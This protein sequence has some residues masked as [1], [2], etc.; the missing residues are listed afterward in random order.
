MSC[1][2]PTT[3][4]KLDVP[5]SML[6][7]HPAIRVVLVEVNQGGDLWADVF[8]GLPVK[9]RTTWSSEPKPV[10]AARLLEEYQTRTVTHADDWD[11]AATI[12]EL[13]A[14]PRAPHD[15]RVDAIGAGVCSVVVS[16]SARVRCCAGSASRSMKRDS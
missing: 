16:S 8:R 6:I 9:V 13:T 11:D 14:F 1:S 7:R 2:P 3:P 5:S 4:R 12:R 15:D 10:R